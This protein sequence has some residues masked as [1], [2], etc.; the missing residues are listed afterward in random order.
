M[1][2]PS[3]PAVDH[4]AGYYHHGDATFGDCRTHGPLQDLGQLEEACDLLRQAL[5]SDENSFA[6]GH[7]TIALRQSNLAVV[8]RDLGQLDEAQDL[9]RQSYSAFLER[10]GPDHP[11]TKN[12]KSHLQNLPE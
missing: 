8:L 7:P 2:A 11:H 6:P 4:I 9:L 10:F 3:L 5:S 1:S 12:V